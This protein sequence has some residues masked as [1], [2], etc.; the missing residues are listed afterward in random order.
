MACFGFQ[1][2]SDNSVNITPLSDKNNKI[3]NDANSIN[4][5]VVNISHKILD[6]L[7]YNYEIHLIS[8]QVFNK[9]IYNNNI[10]KNNYLEYKLVIVDSMGNFLM[11]CPIDEDTAIDYKIQLRN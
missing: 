1:Y 2:I 4:V 5:S 11:H 10:Y 3:I 6:G 9:D 7:C 8:S